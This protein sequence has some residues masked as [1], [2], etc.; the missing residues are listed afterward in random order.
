MK[1]MCAPLSIVLMFFSLT[2]MITTSLS[3]IKTH[4]EKIIDSQKELRKICN[5]NIHDKE[6]RKAI[7]AQLNKILF[8]CNQAYAHAENQDLARS[9]L[10]QAQELLDTV[11]RNP[12]LK[13]K[14]AL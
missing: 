14:A 12:L 7:K 6:P 13:P 3:I 2:C 8:L 10:T 5:L 4:A 9:L 1:Y 11:K